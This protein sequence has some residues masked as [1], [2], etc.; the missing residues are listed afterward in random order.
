MS[1]STDIGQ[2]AASPGRLRTARYALVL[3]GLTAF[4]PL[5]IDM[6]LP[7]LPAMAQDLHAGDATLQL[8]LAAF[9]LGVGAGQLVL[10]PLSDAFGRRKP[11]LAGVALF[12]VASLL[13]VLSPTVELLIAARV[14]Q[15]FGASAGMVIARAAVRDLFSGIEMARFFSMLMLVTG[16]AP[17][18][19]PV[20]GGQLLS[21]TS[22]RGI[23]GALAA[24]GALLL[25]VAAFALPETLPAHRRRPARPAGVLRGYLSLLHDRVFVGYA[26]GAGLAFAAMFTYISAS[27]F[28]LQGTYGLSPQQY[29]LVFGGGAVGLV[30][31]SQVNG[32]L[33]ARFRQH[34]LLVTGLVAGTAGALAM[35][36]ASLAGLG[37]G[38]VLPPLFVAVASVGLVMPNATSLALADHPEMAGSASALLGVLQFTVGGL[39]SPIAGLA[40]EG[41][42]LPMALLMAAFAGLGLVSVGTLTRRRG[43]DQLAEVGVA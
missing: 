38:G 14:L 15:A 4:G 7:A 33:V 39:T 8:T 24:F 30:L 19:A 13:C 34:T 35:V 17:I 32:R 1:T 3:G 43:S 40:G 2:P 37:L 18:L 42:A 6:Y 28:V 11:L 27:S 41:S 21:L 10:G 16:L 9:V 25:I 5:S 12:V 31:A 23:F 36:L 26:L 22:W 20:L 29:S